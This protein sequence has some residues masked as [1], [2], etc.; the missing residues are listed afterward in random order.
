MFHDDI[1]RTMFCRRIVRSIG[2]CGWT[3]AAYV[4]MNTH[5]HLLVDVGDD[6]LPGAMQC[7]FGPYAQEFNRRH[8]RSGHL[9]A[10]PYKLRRIDDETD[11]L[12]VVAYVANN[13]V[14]EGYCPRPQ[15]WPWSSYPG[16]AAYAAPFPFV[17]DTLPLAAVHD[18]RA[19]AQRL[20]R[21]IVERE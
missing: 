21:L 10:A 16:T 12:G 8:G 19:Q 7:L 1:D 3:C 9:K 5:F 2:K 20:L 13:P 11:L 15:D 6:V 18:D 4:L 14:K 17:D